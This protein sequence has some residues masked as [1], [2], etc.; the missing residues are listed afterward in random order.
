MNYPRQLFLA[1]ALIVGAVIVGQGCANGG[2]STEERVVTPYVSVWLLLY[3][4]SSQNT[5]ATGSL[6]GDFNSAANAGNDQAAYD[7]WHQFLQAYDPKDGVFEDG[8]HVRLV[9]WARME[10]V[11]LDHRAAGDAEAE[12]AQ[13]EAMRRSASR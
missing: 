8:M 7:R 1:L 12:R 2:P 13:I 4:E 9:E 10:V 6:R 11:R 3:P 5:A